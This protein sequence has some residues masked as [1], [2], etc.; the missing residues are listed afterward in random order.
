MEPKTIRHFVAS[1]I[2]FAMLSGLFGTM[3][4]NVKSYYGLTEEYTGDEDKNIAEEINDLNLVESL[5][6]I[7]TAITTIQNPDSSRVDIVGA[8]MLT[9][10]GSITA[11]FSILTLPFEILLL[12]TKFYPIPGILITGVCALIVIYIGFIYLSAKMRGEI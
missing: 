8:L 9:A 6:T 3:Y 2:I 1:F 11:I 7:S 12:I 10:F 4:F 5:G